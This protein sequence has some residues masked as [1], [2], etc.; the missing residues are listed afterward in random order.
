MTDHDMKTEYGPASSL[1]IIADDG[2][3]MAMKTEIRSPILK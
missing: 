1:K 3:N 2:K